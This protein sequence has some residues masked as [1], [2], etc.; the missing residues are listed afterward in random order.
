MAWR[1]RP[2]DGFPDDLLLAG[3]ASGDAELSVAFVRRFQSRV[4]GVAMSVL[5]GDARQAEDVAQQAFERAWRHAAVFDPRRGSV[6]T[7]LTAITHHLAIDAVRARRAAPVDPMDLEEILGAAPD[8]PER[9]T[10]AA[11]SA[12]ELRA[13]IRALPA[14]QGRALA[15]AA[16]RGL[17][18]R[19]IAESEGIP[20]GTAKTRIRTAMLRLAAALEP[21]WDPS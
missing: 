17:T 10:L 6:T 8:G 20:L 13:A 15:L 18:A 12:A 1:A 11:E 19:E 21:K 14:E 5:G 4:F 16:F 3:L 9:A 7:W 2:V